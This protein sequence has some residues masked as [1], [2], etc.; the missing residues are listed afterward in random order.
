MCI[1]KKKEKGSV[2]SGGSGV[3]KENLQT[4]RE[5][6]S[7][8]KG[9]ERPKQ[10]K[11]KRHGLNEVHRKIRD[12]QDCTIE[13]QKFQMAQAQKALGLRPNTALIERIA[14]RDK[15]NEKTQDKSQAQQSVMSTKGD[16]A[17][18][19]IKRKLAKDDDTIAPNFKGRSPVAR[20]PGA[21]GG[22][23]TP[24]PEAEELLEEDQV[25]SEANSENYMYNGKEIVYTCHTMVRSMGK[26]EITDVTGNIKQNDAST[27]KCKMGS[28]CTTE[29]T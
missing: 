9:Y 11:E 5:R 13:E 23:N 25:D 17:F 12:S 26:Q 8:R 29:G 28:I 18:S 19:F 6:V 27:R 1:R 22:C 24:N 3:I 4:A 10:Q 20:S 7:Q 14:E 16:I 15:K 2:H 21:D